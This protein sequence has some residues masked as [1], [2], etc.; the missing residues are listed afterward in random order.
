MRQGRDRQGHERS[1]PDRQRNF[2]PGHAGHSRTHASHLPRVFPKTQK[3]SYSLGG[4]R[5]AI[6]FVILHNKC[7]GRDL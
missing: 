3:I 1:E 7:M 2:K 5:P 4:I 6:Y